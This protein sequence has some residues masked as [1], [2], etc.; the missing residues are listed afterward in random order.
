MGA[1]ERC[2]CISATGTETETGA[3]T[4]PITFSRKNLTFNVKLSTCN[5]EGGRGLF[6][7]GHHPPGHE[8][9]VHGPDPAAQQSAE[10]VE[11]L[12]GGIGI[13]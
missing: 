1:L 11:K 10:Q 9:L 5:C 13:H 8:P 12:H 2:R 7:R 6:V 3:Q 4:T